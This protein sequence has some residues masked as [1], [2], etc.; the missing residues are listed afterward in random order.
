VIWGFAL[1]FSGALIAAFASRRLTATFFTSLMLSWLIGGI[2]MAYLL[3]AAGP[4][5]AHLTD[6][7][8][9]ERFTPLR[10][11]LITLLGRDNLVLT[12]QRYLSAGLNVKVALKGGGVSAMPSMHIATATLCLMAARGTRWFWLALLFLGLTF[13]GSV[14]LGYHYA[15]DAPVAVAVAIVCW[16]MAGSI[17][18]GPAQRRPA[19]D[20]VQ[21]GTTATATA[22]EA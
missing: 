2:G 12:S 7:A 3:S 6:R 4:V 15:V 8:L 10:A 18:P 16:K 21:L 13:F 5:F 1:V 20:A 19:Q 22:R 14:Y 9:A 11:E 17:Y